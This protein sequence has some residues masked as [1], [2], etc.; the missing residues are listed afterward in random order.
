MAT[1]TSEA[2]RQD[3]LDPGAGAPGAADHDGA[4]PAGPSRREAEARC[5]LCMAQH[6][7]AASNDPE[8]DAARRVARLLETECPAC[9]ARPGGGR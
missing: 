1:S 3:E 2:L 4:A 5:V 8:A 9:L 7:M 6:L